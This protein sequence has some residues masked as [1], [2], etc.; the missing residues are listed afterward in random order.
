ML[1]D[2][3]RYYFKANTKYRVH[4][5]FVFEILNEVIEDSRHY[6]AFDHLQTLRNRLAKNNKLIEV[7]DLGAGSKKNPG[8]KRK[9]SDILKSAVS[10]DW[11]CRFLFRLV[12][13]LQPDCVLEMGSSLGLSTMAL[14]FGNKSAQMV[15]LEGSPEI[16][17]IAKEN[18]KLLNADKIEVIVGSFDE[19][20]PL[21]LKNLKKIDLAF[22]DGN[23]QKKPTIEYFEKILPFTHPKTVLIFDDIYWSDEM[24]SAWEELKNHH[25]VTMTIDLFWC[26]ILFF[27]TDFKEK[28]HFRLIPHRFKPWQSGFFR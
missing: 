16:A 3:F 6:Y 27:N 18:F 11:Q 26:G 13:H 10:P 17:Q 21:A 12:N 4:S 5:P 7:L 25:A 24:K 15:S 9:V 8:S 14:H 22:I 1:K 19:T 2:I 23:H 20:L 28:Q